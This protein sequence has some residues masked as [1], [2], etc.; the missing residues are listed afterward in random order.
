MSTPCLHNE[1]HTEIEVVRLTDGEGGRVY[2]WVVTVKIHCVQCGLPFR[3]CGFPVG[4]RNFEPTSD[5]TGKI[6]NLPIL[7]YDSEKPLVDC[8]SVRYDIPKP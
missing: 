3:F 2:H 8:D 4:L 5:I 1:F 6:A 7:P